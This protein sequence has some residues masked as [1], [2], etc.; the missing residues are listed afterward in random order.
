[1][2]GEGFLGAFTTF[3]TFM[4]EGLRLFQENEKRYA[5][6]YLGATLLLGLIAFAM[7]FLIG[8]AFTN[9]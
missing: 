8:T 9:Q 5:L 3:S 4:Y 1:M 2:L 6:L 7:G